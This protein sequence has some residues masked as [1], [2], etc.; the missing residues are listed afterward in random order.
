MNDSTGIKST[1]TY[2]YNA[3]GYRA[4]Y[5]LGSVDEWIGFINGVNGARTMI[6]DSKPGNIDDLFLI[7][8]VNGLN[9]EN[10]VLSKGGGGNW[11]G[12]YHVYEL[13]WKSGQST[14]DVDHGASIASSTIPAYVP[15]GYLPVTLN[16]DTLPNGT[17]QVDWVYVRQFRDPE[18]SIS[19]QGEQGL[20]ALSIDNTGY[21]NP[22]RK[23]TKLT[24]QLTIAN[25]SS[26]NAPGVVV[27][28]TLPGNIQIGPVSASQG[29]CEPG[30]IILCDLDTIQANSTASITIIVTPTLDGELINTAEVGSPSKELNYSDNTGEQT[31]LVDSVPPVVNW[32]KP[33]A[34]GE[35]YFTLGGMI[36]L[37]TTAS[38]NDQVDRV[39]FWWYDGVSYW[40]IATE[41]APPYQADFDSKLLA[42]G[43]PYWFEARA[44]DRAGNSNFP[45]DRAFIYIIR[46]NKNF[47]PLVRR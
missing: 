24:Y 32:V 15:G 4:K 46:N 39:E 29:N 6:G 8:S 45:Y 12:G 37:E 5:S 2:L 11:H 40:P 1:S 10:V 16:N 28:D 22:L 3:I 25:T 19:V 41:T 17:L 38:D 13:R 27:T 36:R 7:D 44:Y 20:V 21:P 47:L 34:D 43:I 26:I 23:L 14:G 31:T 33:I 42:P 9:F 35:I 18:P 30:S